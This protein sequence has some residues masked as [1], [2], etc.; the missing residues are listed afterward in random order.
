MSIYEFLERLDADPFDPAL[1]ALFLGSG[2][3]PAQ[4]R[5]EKDPPQNIY[6]A[7]DG[8]ALFPLA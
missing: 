2:T 8:Q 4:Q 3:E 7:A 1:T 5:Q 6:T